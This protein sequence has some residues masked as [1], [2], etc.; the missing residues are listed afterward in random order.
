MPE[1][2]WRMMMS[3]DALAWAAK[4][5][6]GGATDKL[7]LLL[8]ADFADENGS[9][10]PSHKTIA[11]RAE[12]GVSTVER[13]LK[14]LQ[15]RGL[16]VISPRFDK[17]NGGSNRQTSN[18]YTL[19]MGGVKMTGGGGYQNDDPLTSNNKPYVKGFC[20]PHG[21]EQWWIAYPRNNGSKKKSYELWLRAIDQFV[22]EKDLYIKT[23]RFSQSQKG[24]DIQYIPH[25]T[26]W[27]NQRR[28]ETITEDEPQQKLNSLAG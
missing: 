1:T 17:S 18:L 26:T 6:A 9:C 21:F 11:T 2:I 19:K 15:Q 10:Y 4:Q 24:K 8:L 14:R 25:A 22:D 27:L 20:Y 16:L 23:C 12:C 3:W 5:S 13:A 7:I 28:W